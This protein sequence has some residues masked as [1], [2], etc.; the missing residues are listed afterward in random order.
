MVLQLEDLIMQFSIEQQQQE[1]KT[2]QFEEDAEQDNQLQ[3]IMQMLEPL[4]T[5][6]RVKDRFCKIKALQGFLKSG[7]GQQKI[8]AQKEI[9]ELVESLQSLEV[10]GLQPV[11]EASAAAKSTEHD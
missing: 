4:Q 3:L 7:N 2:R 8:Q 6:V 11:V 5:D 9:I 1:A 10:I